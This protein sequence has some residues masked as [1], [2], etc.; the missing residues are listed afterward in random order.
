MNTPQRMYGL[1]RQQTVD[2]CH[3]TSDVVSILILGHTGTGKTALFE[4][5]KA[6]NPD[7]VACF[8]DGA[9]KDTEDMAIPDIKNSDGALSFIPNVELGIHHGKPI[10]LMIDEYPKCNRSIKL[11]LNAL[12][13]ERRFAGRDLPEGSKVILTG[14]LGAEGLGD[15]LEAH[16]ANRLTVVEM[17]KPDHMEHVQYMINN[18]CDPIIMGFAKDNPQLYADFR[19]VKNPDDNPYIYHPQAVGRTAFWSCR[20]AVKLS[21]VFKRREHLDEHTLTSVAIGTIGDR[22]GLDLMAF[23]K[24][25][26]QLPSHDSIKDNPNTATVP[27]NASAVCM[28]IFRSLAGMTADFISPFMTYLDRLSPE[29]QG[30]FANGVMNDKYHARKLVTTNKKFSEWCLKHNHMFAS[31]KK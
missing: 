13:N 26:N 5:L 24:L 12:I 7:L 25:A 14:N 3:N 29:A 15:L 27:N 17:Q 1:S 23:A 8:F 18:N 31:D 6:L 4:E 28:V 21:D 11:K 9:N 2:L 22:A 10:L 19:D 30:M 16:T 20:S